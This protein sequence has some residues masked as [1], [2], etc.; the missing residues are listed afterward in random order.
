MFSRTLL[1]RKKMGDDNLMKRSS[2][3]KHACS[4]GRCGKGGDTCL[5]VEGDGRG[6]SRKNINRGNLGRR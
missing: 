1:G 5:G 2:K 6:S 3:K 4:K